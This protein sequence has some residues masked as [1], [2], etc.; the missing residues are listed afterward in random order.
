MPPL[1]VDSTWRDEMRARAETGLAGVDRSGY[2][3]SSRRL[4]RTPR[5]SQQ[6]CWP[7]AM[8]ESTVST[9]GWPIGV[10]VDNRDEYRPRPTVDGV[11]AEVSIVG[12]AELDHNSYDL[13]KV[14]GDGRF[15]ALLSLF[16]DERW[17]SPGLVESGCCCRHSCAQPKVVHRFFARARACP[18]AR[19]RRGRRRRGRL[20][21]RPGSASPASSAAGS[22]CRSLRCTR[23]QPSAARRG[24]PI[25]PSGVVEQPLLGQGR[26]ERLGDGVVKAGS[27]GA[28][29]LGDPGVVAGLAER[30]GRCTDRR[31]RSDGPSPAAA[32]A[33]DGHLKR[34]RR[35]ARSACC[36]AIAQPTIRRL[37][38]SCT[39]ARYSQPSPVLICLMSAAQTLFG[40]VGPKVTA[41][42]VSEGLDALHAAPCSPC[43]AAAGERPA[44]PPA[45][46]SRSTRFSPTR[47]PS[48]RSIA[49]T[50]GLP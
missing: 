30:R 3:E 36:G 34:R 44:S 28:H 12:R 50:R 40:R 21:T 20:R 47:I 33:P 27:D 17:T 35:P 13:W 46:I 15:Y 42:Q 39:A 10:V 49:C 8:R 45:R 32:G 25:L 14:Y 9:F 23:R 7:A 38:R 18:C 37:K 29:R 1:D 5:L 31:D 41:D 6:R 16:E 24:W 48:R 22:G 19:G 11:E 26:E 43:V 2:M 4:C